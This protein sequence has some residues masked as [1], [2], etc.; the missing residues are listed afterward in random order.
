VLTIALLVICF[1]LPVLLGVLF[2]SWLVLVVP[3]LLWPLF[4]LG[5]DQGWWGDGE[6]GEGWEPALVYALIGGLAAAGLGVIIGRGLERRG[7][8]L[9]G[10][11]GD[12][13]P[14]ATSAPHSGS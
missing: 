7:I 12:G 1:V 9:R 3:F 5:D 13:E 8:V 4:F 10:Q 11:A 14:S 6:L 2:R